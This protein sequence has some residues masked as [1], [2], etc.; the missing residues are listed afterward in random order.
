MGE[1]S[2]EEIKRMAEDRQRWRREIKHDEQQN[3]LKRT[4]SISAN[5]S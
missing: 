1:G 5:S 3:M 4:A 2:Q